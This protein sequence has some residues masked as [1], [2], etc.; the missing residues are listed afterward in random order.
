M[1][2]G[3]T[4]QSLALL[5]HM[6]YRYIR[7]EKGITQNCSFNNQPNVI[8]CPKPVIEE[9]TTSIAQFLDP[10]SFR[11]HVYK[12]GRPDITRENL[13]SMDGSDI[14]LTTPDRLIVQSSPRSLIGQSWEISHFH[15]TSI[16]SVNLLS[17]GFVAY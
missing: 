1:G 17:L 8:V 13:Q 4:Y 14:I 15:L 16:R 6:R 7:F 10:K 3:K 2:L 11:V 5:A 12:P 9:W